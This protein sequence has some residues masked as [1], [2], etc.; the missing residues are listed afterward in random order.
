MHAI[1]LALFSDAM[2]RT[3]VSLQRR[4]VLSEHATFQAKKHCLANS[5]AVHGV[6]A[7]LDRDVGRRHVVL[8]QGKEG[9]K[10]GERFMGAGF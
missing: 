2:R 5:Q 10:R 4:R 3:W 8:E 9:G 6:L 1:S 7:V